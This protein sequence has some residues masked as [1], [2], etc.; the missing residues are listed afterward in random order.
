[1]SHLGRPK[2]EFSPEFSLRPVADYLANYYG[3]DV[4]FAEDCVGEKAETAVE[5]AVIGQVVVLENLR[6][7]PEEKKNDEEF[8]KKLAKLGDV[9]VN[10]AFGSAHRA[11]ASTDAVARL[12]E[13]RYAG[14]LMIDEIEYLGNTVSDP[15]HP[16]VA[17]MGGAKI[18]G[19]IDVI[20]NLI[21]KC[22]SILIGG[23][24]MYTFYKAMDLEIG[25]S[26]L[27]EDKIELAKELIE[28]AKNES[29]ELLL[30][31]D[32]IVADKFDN[33]ANFKTVKDSEIPAD[34][35]GVDIGAETRTLFT[36]TI[37]K[38][39]TVVWN[40]PMGVFEMPNFASGTL[41]IAEAL[42]TATEKGAITIIGGGD[43]AAAI[44]Q[45]NFQNKVTHVSTGGGASLEYLEG[46][47]LPGIAALDC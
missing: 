8:A 34:W 40:G 5:E 35:L 16:F 20:K 26:L 12:F 39:K 45:M 6:F 13:K 14:Y 28:K 25:K 17:V 1:M 3:Y 22:D 43:S 38:A 29:C 30:P 31:L 21:S 11:H 42:A 10:D 19:K 7:H 23:G 15:G 46:K 32:T 33:E 2:G 24:M 37:T 44:R 47:T 36:D 4:I 9:Y 41:S 18:S 27:E